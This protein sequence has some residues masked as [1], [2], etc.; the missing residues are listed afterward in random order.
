VSLAGLEYLLAQH[1]LWVGSRCGAAGITGMST[2]A[3]PQQLQQQQQQQHQSHAVAT[4]A[5]WELTFE[6]CLSNMSDMNLFHAWCMQH[7]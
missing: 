4:Q 3:A 2:T 6:A 7:V 5:S 1:L